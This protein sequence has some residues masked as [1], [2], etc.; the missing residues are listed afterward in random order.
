IFKIYY[1]LNGGTNDAGNPSVYTVED[2]ITFK[3]PTRKGYDFNG[4]YTDE[5]L[6]SEISSITKGSVGNKT[7]HAKWTPITYY[8]MYNFYSGTPAAYDYPKTYTIETPT[9]TLANPTYS[10]KVFK[11]W[12]DWNNAQRKH[13]YI[14]PQGSIGDL[15]ISA[16]WD[17][18]INNNE[19]GNGSGGGSGG[20]ETPNSEITGSSNITSNKFTTE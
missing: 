2:S 13:T 9:I 7:L 12:S 15:V 20:N 4:W 11:G 3:A 10:G 17:V 8:I 6:T 1:K 18:D 19:N 14:I 16:N 5:A